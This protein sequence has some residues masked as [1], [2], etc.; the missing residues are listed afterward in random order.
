MIEDF[1]KK[2]ILKAMEDFNVAKYLMSLPEEKILAGAV[3]FHS[4]Q[5][6][7]KLLKAYLVRHEID[8]EKTHDLE[9]LLKLCCIQD[10]NFEN[11]SVG[12]LTDYAVEIRYPDEFYI[13]SVEEAR[14]CFEIASKI[15]DF[16]FFKMGIKEE[17]LKSGYS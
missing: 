11:I 1:V 10:K 16:L 3:C 12:N 13:P 15:K 4:Q 8:F 9:T 2:W 7:E 17:E 6:V 5:A 14:E